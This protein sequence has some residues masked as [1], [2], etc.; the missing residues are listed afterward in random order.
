MEKFNVSNGSKLTESRCFLPDKTSVNKKKT[1][2]F[3]T[4]F[5][6]Q[7][8]DSSLYL[9]G[10]IYQYVSLLLLVTIY[11]AKKIEIK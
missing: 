7:F 2:M 1:F 6:R 8:S 9:I 3:W 4:S 11:R 5:E 10:D